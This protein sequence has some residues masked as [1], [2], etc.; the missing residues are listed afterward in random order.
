LTLPTFPP[1]LTTIARVLGDPGLLLNQKG[2]V[3]PPPLSTDP[4]PRSSPCKGLTSLRQALHRR[5]PLVPFDSLFYPATPTGMSEPPPLSISERDTTTPPGPKAKGPR[6]PPLVERVPWVPLLRDRRQRWK[7][8]HP[9]KS[10]AGSLS[11]KKNLYFIF[12]REVVTLL[13][14]FAPAA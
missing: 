6:F 13:S 1:P 4:P 3:S 11:K 10:E 7:P 9:C 2:K 8:G 12:P 5:P 14:R